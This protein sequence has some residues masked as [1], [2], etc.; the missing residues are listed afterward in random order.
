MRL[1]APLVAPPQPLV[2]SLRREQPVPVT[3]AAPIPN[4]QL[5]LAAESSGLPRYA[6]T[7]ERRA[8]LNTIRYAEGTWARGENHGYR[9]MFGGGMVT[10]LERHPDRVNY[11]GGYASAAAGAYQFMPFTWT[12]ASRALQLEGFGPHVQDQAA[13]FLIERRG[14]LNLA[15]QGRFTPELAASLS[16][17]WAS[18]PTLAGSSYYGQPVQRYTVLR[19]F[20]ERNLADLRAAAA[21]PAELASAP[22]CEPVDSL[23]CRLESLGRLGPRSSRN[24]GS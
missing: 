1:S 17:E 14:A 22:A 8:L 3:T 10:S 15:D 7:P 4:S 12:R 13:L 18:F 20:Y 5:L 11:S 9:I 24:Q 19:S 16:P 6:I 21:P 2:A 23:R